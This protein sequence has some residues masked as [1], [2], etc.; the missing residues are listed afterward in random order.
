MA[1][2]KQV[3]FYRPVLEIVSKVTGG[4]PRNDLIKRSADRLE[5]SEEDRSEVFGGKSAINVVDH[6]VY[7]A[8]RKLE[9]A[10]LLSRPERG[11][12]EI[13]Q[14][15]TDL[16]GEHQGPL[17]RADLQ[18]LAREFQNSE[19]ETEVVSGPEENDQEVA[20]DIAPTVL[21]IQAYSTHTADLASELLA[22]IKS[23]DPD[24]FED[25]VADLLVKMGY[26]QARPRGPRSK[27]GGIDGVID[28]D[29]L[30]LD[31]VL[32]QA[33]RWDD[34]AVGQPQVQAFSGTLVGAGASKGVF[35]TTSR[36]TADAQQFADNLSTQ[37][38]RLINGQEL[39][40]LMIEYGV[41]VVIAD[42]YA[43]KKLDENYF[44]HHE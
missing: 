41:G 35:I 7:S 27:D 9:D 44:G 39:A 10:G 23:S 40:N 20:D 31:K 26:G 2:P 21:M 4:I 14:K 18:K 32:L 6:R 13:T 22:V 17:S 3:A 11:I 15:G 16:L 5:I 24:D 43:I 33:K 37:T 12:F 42:T 8:A 25:L 36:F 28:Q 30:G 29:K 19:E 1:V 38:I 34:N